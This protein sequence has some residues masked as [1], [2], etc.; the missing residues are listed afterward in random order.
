M[1]DYSPPPQ[2]NNSIHWNFAMLLKDPSYHISHDL[3]SIA[4]GS[5]IFLQDG[6][7]DTYLALSSWCLRCIYTNIFPLISCA[8]T[9]CCVVHITHNPEPNMNQII[10]IEA[11]IFIVLMV[12]SV[13]FGIYL[14]LKPLN[15]GRQ[16][17]HC[18]SKIEL[19][20]EMSSDLRK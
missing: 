2:I 8:L 9:S 13:V 17:I 5:T 1:E 20:C 7:F 6:K 15:V 18:K 16:N 14:H 10:Y 19:H 11:V 12:I 3:F 4:V